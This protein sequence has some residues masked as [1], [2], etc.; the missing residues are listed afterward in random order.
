MDNKSIPTFFVIGV[1]KSATSSIHSILSQDKR[2]SLPYRKET[3]FFS[4]NYDN[5]IKWYLKMFKNN[6]YKIRG[7]VDPSYIHYSNSLINISKSI[8]TPKFIIIFRKPLDRAYSHYLMSKK[9]SFENLSFNDALKAECERIDNDK[10]DFSFINHSYLRRGEY[11]DLINTC[12]KIFPDSEYLFLKFDDFL[13]FKNR[14]NF[15][16]KIYNFL[17]ISIYSKLNYN[18]HINR[19]SKSKYF[20]LSKILYNNT[21][22]R[23]FFRFLIPFISYRYKII[24]FI[25]KF[26]SNYLPVNIYKCDYSNIDKRFIEWNNDESIKLN[27]ITN[28]NVDDWIIQ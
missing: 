21:N 12:M 5:G 26:N 13:E 3:H 27:E 17:D 23:N 18:V 20:F 1:Q 19:S 4:T 24:S 2:F 16:K 14:R 11:S 22:L 25:E 8:K 9:R 10:D 7:E 28:L 15:I 6:T